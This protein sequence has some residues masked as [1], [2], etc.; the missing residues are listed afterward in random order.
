MAKPT[1]D[2]VLKVHDPM[3]SDNFEIIIANVPGGGDAKALRIQC[4]TAVKPGSTLNE[5][6]IELF[7]HAVVHAGALTYTH[8][9]SLT[10]IEDSKGTITKA[11]EGWQEIVRSKDTQ[12]GEF[13]ENYAVDAEFIIF[14]QKGEEA[15]K[16][17]IIN[18][19]PNQI[20]D[21]NFDGAQGTQAIEIGAN[22]K[23][24]YLR[25]K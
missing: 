4:K 9:L 8:D 5:V 6:L 13:K 11:L 17:D 14:D 1:L 15:M 22:F 19:W 3:L 24:D 10:Y 18:I 23:F 21:L 7:G 12:S 25:L 2:E 16:Y 20:P